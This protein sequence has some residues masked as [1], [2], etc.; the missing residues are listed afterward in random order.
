MSS[1]RSIDDLAT[2]PL[3]GQA[4]VA[5]RMVRRAAKAL[6]RDDSTRSAIEA[7]CDAIDES[8][9]RGALTPAARQAAEGG[10]T[11]QAAL[12][13]GSE[14]FREA[15][16]WALDAAAAAHD[17]QDF[18]IDATVTNSARSAIAAI[19]GDRRVA[20]LQLAILSGGDVDQVAFA[21]GEARIGTYDA[22]TDYVFER[23]APV[24]G[25]TLSPVPVSA[26][27]QA[28]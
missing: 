6:P 25:L 26:E 7:A 16:R 21:S 24:H 18:P 3:W 14:S 27:S 12:S 8:A 19:A 10:G 4:L 5:S 9:R 1:L 23:L 28:R 11:G 15:L 22:L 2:L 13:P 17:A 20:P